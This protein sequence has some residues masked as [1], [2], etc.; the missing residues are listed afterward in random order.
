MMTLAASALF[1][2]G[3]AQ[4]ATATRRRRR[5]AMT[6]LHEGPVAAEPRLAALDA[7][8]RTTRVGQQIQ[9]ALNVAGV[10]RP[11]LLVAAALFSASVAGAWLLSK[12]LAPAFGVVGLAAPLLAA[13]SYVRRG[14]ARRNEAFIAQMPE[15]ARLLA[16]A[17]DAGY[18]IPGAIVEI[19]DAVAEPAR[20]E[21]RQTANEIALG[22][23]LEEA[24]RNTEERVPSREVSVLMSTLIVCSRSGGS[25]VTSLR[26]ISSTLETR[27]EV[28]REVRTT[29][30][31][32]L[33]TGYLV[34]GMGFALL[35]LLNALRPGTVQAMTTNVFGQAALVTAMGLFVCGL[36]AIRRITRIEP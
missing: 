22:A 18:S 1:V 23:S 14:R 17:V 2:A 6:V 27:K 32:A 35:F 19:V 16:N 11:P 10:A 5:L 36:L 24:L 28:R 31:Q 33:F 3:V 29:L 4:L 8:F 26:D 9:S 15:V 12:A 25:L 13:R 34:V 20:S 30:A 21:L 7:R